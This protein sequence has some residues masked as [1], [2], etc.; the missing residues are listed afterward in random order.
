[1]MQKAWHESSY[2]LTRLPTD[3]RLNLKGSWISKTKVKWASSEWAEEWIFACTHI[4][5]LRISKKR[6]QKNLQFH[7]SLQCMC[8]SRQAK[9]TVI[10]QQMPKSLCQKINKQSSAFPLGHSSHFVLLLVLLRPVN[11]RSM[12]KGISCVNVLG[13]SPLEADH[14]LQ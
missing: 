9:P 13:S 2:K 11:W 14:R 4:S 1:M 7:R 6:N 10:L 12:F 3:C 8:Q 5:R